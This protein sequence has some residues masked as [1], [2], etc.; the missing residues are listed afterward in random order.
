MRAFTAHRG[1]F[2]VAGVERE[3]VVATLGETEQT[4]A[5]LDEV[6]AGQVPAS[7]A[8]AE[9]E[10]AREAF[11]GTQ[12]ADRAGRMPRSVDDLEFAAADGNP[13]AVIE[14]TGDRDGLEIKSEPGGAAEIGVPQH[15]GRLWVG[16]N[17]GFCVAPR[18][19]APRPVVAGLAAA[20]FV[21]S[22]CE[23]DGLVKPTHHIGDVVRVI[24]VG[25]G[26]DDG[27][28]NPVPFGASV[29][30]NVPQ[31]AGVDDDGPTCRGVRDKVSVGLQRRAGH[32]LDRER[33]H[34]S[35]PLL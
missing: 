27:L 18:L 29:Q 10:V 3:G 5:K 22:R 4:G 28:Q 2:A 21:A 23:A 34:R 35:N 24:D 26:Q 1:A 12:E 7:D 14:I 16:K 8:V 31:E 17:R 25:V 6:A 9:E 20:R 19:A 32:H 13:V 30:Q 11:F 33:S 15:F